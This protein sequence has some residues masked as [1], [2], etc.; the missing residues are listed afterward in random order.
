MIGLSQPKQIIRQSILFLQFG[1]PSMIDWISDQDANMRWKAILIHI[2]IRNI[3]KAL[4]FLIPTQLL[5]HGQWWSYLSTQ[6]LQIAQCLDL[7]VL[8]ILHSGH[9]SAGLMS[10]SNSKKFFWSFY[11]ITPGSLQEAFKNAKITIKV[12]MVL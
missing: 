10:R 8:I 12:V 6:Q 9:K 11:F 3:I 1:P 4:W 2:E 7:A 5:I